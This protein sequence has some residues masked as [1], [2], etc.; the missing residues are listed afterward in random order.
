MNHDSTWGRSGSY[1]GAN[2][3]SEDQEADMEEGSD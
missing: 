2:T 3:G 1:R